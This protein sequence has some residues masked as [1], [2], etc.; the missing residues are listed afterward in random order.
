MDFWVYLIL[1]VIT[2]ILENGRSGKCKEVAVWN[3]EEVNKSALELV[4]VFA[5]I[6]YLWITAQ[7]NLMELFHVT[8]ILAQYGME[9]AVVVVAAAVSNGNGIIKKDFF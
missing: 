4:S 3:A 2:A 1:A 9:T 7:V 5:I 8:L 6:Q